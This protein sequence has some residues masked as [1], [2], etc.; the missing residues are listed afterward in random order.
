[1]HTFR[2]KGKRHRKKDKMTCGKVDQT[3]M[4]HLSTGLSC[5]MLQ[6][7]TAAPPPDSQQARKAANNSKTRFQNILNVFSMGK[8]GGQTEEDSDY[9]FS[10]G[11]LFKCLCCPKPAEDKSKLETSAI[12]EK[13]D[14]LEKA[15]VEIKSG[16]K[17][18]V[19][20]IPSVSEDS[21]A[22]M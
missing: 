2:Q 20:G 5:S 1:M 8:S 3:K 11:N 17:D 16:N 12:L 13:L 4:A 6:V 22:E 14:R 10:C 21:S 19:S 18:S 7:L 9:G 15:M